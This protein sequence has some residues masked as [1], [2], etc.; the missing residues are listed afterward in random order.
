MKAMRERSTDVLVIGGGAAGTRAALAA[1]ESGSAVILTNKGPLAKSGITLTAGGGLEAPFHPDDSPEQYFEDVIH[2][3]YYLGDQN[4]AWALATDACQR[5]EDL[6]RYGTRFRKNEDG[7]YALN[8][9][10]GFTYPRNV[11]FSAGG[12]G[13]MN[14]LKQSCIANEGIT[15]MED[16]AVTGLVTAASYGSAS[17]GQAVAGAVGIDLRTG[18]LILIRAKAT[19]IATGGCQWIWEVTDCPADSTGDGLAMAYRIGAEIIDMEMILFYPS[20]VIW[21]P[22]ARG[23]FVHY[24]FLDPAILDGR[25]MDGEGRDVLPKPAPVRDRAM[26]MMYDAIEQGRGHEHGGLWWYV[27]DSAK[28]PE[29]V[30]RFL[31]TPQYNYIK[32]QGID[33]TTEKVAVAPGAHYQLGGIFVDENCRTTVPG[34]FAAPECAGNYEGANRLS[35]S[36]LAGTQVFG[37]RAGNAAHAWA[38]GAG[39]LE[40]DR[41]S[42]DKEIARV[43]TRLASGRKGREAEVIAVRNR[44]RRAAQQYIAV[45]RDPEGLATFSRMLLD[46]REELGGLQVAD[47]GA[48]NQCLLDVLELEAMLEVAELIAGSALV[49]RESR[50]HHFRVDYPAKDDTNWLKHT[51]V[52]RG[53]G[54]SPEYGTRP[55]MVTRLPLPVK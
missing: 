15:I 50:G 45:K 20:V 55:V 19:V 5:V 29:M 16:L 40:P 39:L 54:G 24:E 32:R 2:H 38:G 34:L 11:L 21:P 33:P 36:A 51:S 17:D 28:G 3:G 13:M 30:K 14:P 4:M 47:L 44:L 26:R 6:E 8:K 25:I 22:A 7:S 35:G 1:A 46:M 27:G 23:A 42:L 37:A 53:S 43:A 31:N 18:E 49:R 41:A 9:F 48:F 12:Y 10:P 52:V